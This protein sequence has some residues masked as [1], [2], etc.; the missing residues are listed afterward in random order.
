MKKFTGAGIALLLGTTAAYAGGMDR[1]GQSITA[2]F[3]EGTYAEISFGSVSPDVTGT[4]IM[5][6]APSGN[7]APD[8]TQ[9]G[10]AYKTDLNEDWSLAVIF[11]Q[12]FGANVEYSTA[13]YLVNGTMADVKTSSITVVGQY[14][15]NENISV[16]AGPRYLSASGDYKR[17]VA[18]NNYQASYASDSTLGYV[19]GAAYEMP[20]I[21]LR[22]DFTY[23]SAT[24][25]DLAGTIA[26]TTTVAAPGATTLTAKLPQSVN[27]N[28]QSG[29]AE[30]TLAFLN[31]RWADWSEAELVDANPA[32]TFGSADAGVLSD[33]SNT[34]VYTYTLGVGR[35]FSDN[36]SGLFSIG[37]EKS[38]GG[39]ASNLTPTDGYISYQLGGAY[40]FENGM[41]LSG[42]IRY[43]NLGD[44][45]TNIGSF[46][47]NSATAIGL[48]LAYNY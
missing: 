44:A 18:T 14:Q 11:D 42:G 38:I 25:L 29:V 16:F 3:E 41:E 34:D 22:A 30:N 28:L 46:T 1:S 12:P 45:T 5:G 6:G 8:Y 21:A 13:G 2:L 26:S 17:Q 15:I 37:Y 36:F 23:S 10:L 32:S 9:I 39:E 27:F 47:D 33:F 40:T 19:V 48:K 4:M 35:R 43:V 24:E 7:M 20:E 31:V